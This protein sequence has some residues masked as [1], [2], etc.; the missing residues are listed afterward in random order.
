VTGRLLSYTRRGAAEAEAIDV[1]A[2]LR[3]LHEILTHTLGGTV[4]TR[5]SLASE[6]P[7]V[8]TDKGQLETALIN[9][10]VN[11]RDAMPAGGTLTIAALP[12]T[13]DGGA[14]GG[15]EAGEHVRIAV[16]DTGEGMD[17][18]T[19]ARVGDPF[20]TTK[21]AG[22]GTGLGLATVRRFLEQSGGRLDIESAPG[23]GT[24]V[25]LRLP[26]CAAAEAAAVA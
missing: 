16:I 15:R 7:P 10:A 24:V 2:M 6:L 9:L 11:A 1:A 23:R 18:A 25:S 13:A 8:R 4:T 5:L 17:A 22:L 3:E 20:F 21:P 12:E 14:T 26:A 19:L